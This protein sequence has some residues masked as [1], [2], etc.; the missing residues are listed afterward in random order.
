MIKAHAAISASLVPTPIK[1]VSIPNTEIVEYARRALRSDRTRATIPPNS[2]VSPPTIISGQAQ[3]EEPPRIGVNRR[4]KK[5]PALTM[6]A[7]W[8]YADTGVGAFMASGNQK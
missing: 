7:E 6:V 8:R 4:S 2:M 3:N 1:K 5:I